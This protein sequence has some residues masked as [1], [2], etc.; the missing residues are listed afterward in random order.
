MR[1]LELLH[2]Y[3]WLISLKRMEGMRDASA[4]TGVEG[5]WMHREE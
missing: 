2:C 4:E 3:V 5:Q 1:L